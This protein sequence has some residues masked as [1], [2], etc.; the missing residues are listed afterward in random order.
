[1]SSN[2]AHVVNV[3]YCKTPGK[4]VG[5]HFHGLPFF[6]YE[7]LRGYIN[8]NTGWKDEPDYASFQK[9]S[10]FF[11]SDSYATS[12]YQLSGN[13]VKDDPESYLFIEFWS[14]PENHADCALKIIDYLRHRSPSVEVV[15]SNEAELR[16]HQARAWLQAACEEEGSAC[17]DIPDAVLA[18]FV[19]RSRVAAQAPLRDAWAVMLPA[20]DMALAMGTIEGHR[21]MI[22]DIERG[23]S[24]ARQALNEDKDADT[25]PA[26]VKPAC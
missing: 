20:I 21:S 25:R 18:R 12:R 4:N 14:S 17:I 16:V 13:S 2:A 19:Q 3:E 23:R 1:M 8:H 7:D 26:R 6:L 5:L 15:V 24:L 10:L 11:Q 22:Q 9:A